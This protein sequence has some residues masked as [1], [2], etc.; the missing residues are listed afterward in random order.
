MARIKPFRALRPKKELVKDIACPPYDVLDRDEALKIAENNPYS[1]L[2]VIK[3]E[4]D[5]PPDID[6]YDER[7]YKKGRENLDKFIENNYI[8]QD[9]KSQFYIYR[10]VW[11]NHTQIG[12]V[13]CASVEDY[14]KDII[15][16]HEQT[17]EEK[18]IDRT[19]HILTLNAQTGPVFL[20][21]I[22]RDEIDSLVAE[23]MNGKPEYDFTSEDGVAHTVWVVE[24]E[25]HIRGFVDLFSDVNPLYVAD[26]HHRSAAATRVKKIKQ[27]ENPVHTG[28]EEY[29]F[30]L[31]VIFPHNQMKILPYN[32]VVKDL[33]G[34]TT[35][36]FIEEIKEKFLCE[37]MDV[38]VK[39]EKKH[40]FGMFIHG[41]WYLLEAKKGTYPEDDPVESL[42]VAILQNN[43]LRPILGIENPRKDKRISFVGGI[44]GTEELERLVN[45]G[46]FRV[47]FS[48]YPT[49]IEDLI[50]VADAGRFM[51]PKSTWFEPK[52]KSGLFVH[53]LD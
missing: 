49:S 37:P 7:V 33:N 24:N 5:L 44:K 39:P 41:K 23:I 19:K 48:M 16:K 4:I 42:D 3:P 9:E 45:T 36:K 26:G 22:A 32:R 50:R 29:N 8:F 10:Q 25:E 47:A 12:L 1:F 38:P 13:A 28:E 31:T 43:L 11:K 34:R 51:P 17:R 15:K 46:K 52:L 35:E 40:T 21:Y 2:H 30:F 20:T 53:L 6:L 14:E 18:E 27:E